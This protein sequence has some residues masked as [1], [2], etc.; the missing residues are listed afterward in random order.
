MQEKTEME[1]AAQAR[2]KEYFRNGCNCAETVFGAIL[3]STQTEYPPEVLALASGFGG[4]IGQSRHICGAVTGAVMALGLIYGR[5]EPMSPEAP[6]L[7]TEVYPEFAALFQD[8]EARCGS[9]MCSEL[10]RDFADFGSIERRRHC[11]GIVSACVDIAAAQIAASEG[12]KEPAL[13]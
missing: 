11:A 8:L 1:T 5:R 13:S 10:T 7:K 12:A 4:G 2:A 3:H 9:V 6:V